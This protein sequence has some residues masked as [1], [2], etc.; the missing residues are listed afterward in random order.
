MVKNLHY[1]GLA[2]TIVT[3]W[4]VDSANNYERVTCSGFLGFVGLAIMSGDMTLLEEEMLG[5][6]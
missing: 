6:S 5:D 3:R 4:F 1:L 2:A